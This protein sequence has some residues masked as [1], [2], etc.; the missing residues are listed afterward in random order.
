MNT[1]LFWDAFPSTSKKSEKYKK[2]LSQ[3]VKF[4]SRMLM[5]AERFFA[6]VYKRFNTICSFGLVAVVL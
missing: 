5:G 6:A 4:V 2:D 3:C 1:T